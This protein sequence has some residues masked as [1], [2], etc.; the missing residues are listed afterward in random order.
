[1]SPTIWLVTEKMNKLSLPIHFDGRRFR[2]LVPRRNGFS[3]LLRW[4]LSR[5]RGPWHL[6]YDAQPSALPPRSS[7][8]LRITFV[9]HS[10]FLLQLN[11][12]NILTDPI[13][14]ERASPVSWAG[15]RRYRAPGIPFEHLP[16][17][18]LV[19]LSHDHYDHM[20]MPTLSRLAREHRPTIYTGLGNARRL[21]KSGIG[22]VVELDWW[23]EAAARSDMWI[24]AVPAQHFSGRGLFDRDKTLW[25]GFV[26]QTERVS[27]YFAGDTGAGP[28]IA[29]IAERF[30]ELDLSILP[31]GAYR[32]E[33]FMGEVHMSPR[34]AVEAHFTLG[35]PITVASHFGTF[36]LA[37]DGEA[38]PV[39]ELNAVLAK[40]NMGESEFWVLEF[41]EGREV[42]VYTVCR[43]SGIAL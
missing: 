42:P 25:C 19:L 21:A 31:I 37:D 22:N 39:E 24:T 14:S 20:D 11:G 36:D 8:A 41:G 27:L 28:Q 5:K 2:N 29:Q 23:Q 35:A 17:I 1:M 30:P 34:E 32:P 38:E 7:E 33:W 10:T 15:P 43:P 16:P 40:S 18:D 6:H 9:N 13:W 26:L 4:L 3:A 12:I